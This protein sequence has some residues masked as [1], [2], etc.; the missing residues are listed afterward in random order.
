MRRKT[1]ASPRIGELLRWA[2][3]RLAAADGA[4]ALDGVML[5][6]H[7]LGRQRAWLIAH[8]ND[9]VD[10]AACQA[11]EA[12]VDSRASGIPVAYLTGRRDFHAISLEVTPDTLIPRPE[13]ELLVDLALES[14]A[15]LKAPR[16]ADL[17]TGSGTVALA[18][19]IARPDARLVATDM[20]EKA[21]DVAVR[22][23]RSLGANN[24]VF[25]HGDWLGALDD[26]S[27]DVVVSNPPYVTTDEYRSLPRDVTAEPRAALDGG[28]DGL[29]AVRTIAIGVNAHLAR[30]GSVMIEH[31][32]LQGESVRRLLLEAGLVDVETVADL[33]GHERV[34]K[35][36]H[37]A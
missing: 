35:G 28:C 30:N 12:L 13:T 9:I 19:A 27:F 3:T 5:L 36:Y 21:L 8:D 25:R 15:T 24:V 2:A 20:S 26:R 31:G 10:A 7:V 34:T 6:G 18:I 14:V 16:I 32:A 33:A 29:D 11:F 4:T 23:A 1:G 17:G 37:P 22:N